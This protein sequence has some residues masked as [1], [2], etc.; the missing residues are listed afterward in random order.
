MVGK[1][2]DRKKEELDAL[3]MAE[4]LCQIADIWG[5][6][7][8][9]VDNSKIGHIRIVRG[10]PKSIGEEPPTPPEAALPPGKLETTRDDGLTE[11]EAK[12]LYGG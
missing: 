4:T 3:D 8:L 1:M 12:T 7:E 10:G 5:L 11:E 6:H 2:R 9:S